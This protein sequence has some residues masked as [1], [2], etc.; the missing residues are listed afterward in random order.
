MAYTRS[1]SLL[2]TAL[3]FNLFCVLT[4]Q[5]HFKLRIPVINLVEV[6]YRISCA[7]RL[8]KSYEGYFGCCHLLVLPSGGRPFVQAS[9]G[10]S[11]P[12]HVAHNAPSVIDLVGMHSLLDR[13]AGQVKNQSGVGVGGHQ[14][15][16]ALAGPARQQIIKAL[17]R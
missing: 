16:H 11:M 8:M 2:Q 6:M 5:E 9:V 7:S 13:D 10:L 3:P 17:L 12:R 4:Q 14:A 1:F 15:Q